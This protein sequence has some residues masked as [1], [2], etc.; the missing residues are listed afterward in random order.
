MRKI[1]SINDFEKV[2]AGDGDLYYYRHITDTG[3]EVCLELCFSGF[4]VAVYKD[5]PEG[6]RLMALKRCTSTSDYSS[7]PFNY[8]RTGRDMQVAIDIANQILGAL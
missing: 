5:G 8:K 4:D 3:L 2:S 7:D 1:L 6:H